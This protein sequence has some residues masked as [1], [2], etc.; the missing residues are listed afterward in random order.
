M[1]VLFLTNVGNRD[2]HVDGA[3]LAPDE[4]RARGELIQSEYK[5]RADK[6][7]RD[8]LSAPLIEP[9]LRM[10]L[11]A[12][13]PDDPAEVEVVL[14]VTDQPEAGTDP[15]HRARD[16]VHVGA[17]LERYLKAR[18]EGQQAG[19]RVAAVRSIK[20]T[21]NPSEHDAMFAFFRTE[22]SGRAFKAEA[23]CIYVAAVGGVPAANFALLLNAV[24]RFGDRCIPLY[25]PEGA[26][27]PIRLDVG[28][29]IR[30]DALRDVARHALE[31]FDFGRAARL[32][33]ELGAD[34]LLVAL[35][36]HAEHRL[37]F[38]FDRALAALD[39]CAV[40][41]GRDAERA[42]V[43]SLRDELVQLAERADAAA[44]IR[45]LFFNLRVTWRQGRYVDVLLRLFRLEEAILRHVVERDCRVP[46]DSVG[47][48]ADPRFVAFVEGDPGLKSHFEANKAGGRLLDYRREPNVPILS[49]LL[50][51]L[52][53]RAD[54][55]NGDDYRAVVEAVG[56]LEALTTLRNKSIGAH[57]FRGVSEAAIRE[58]YGRDCDLLADLEALLHT[59]GIDATDDPLVRV[60]D[61]VR[62]ALDRE[63]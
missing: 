9:C 13:A 24:H 41:A 59:V 2:L 46:T 7:Y 44:L 27:A 49:H 10:A 37:H 58:A 6:A 34:G 11:R 5:K 18:Y 30:R 56:R 32:L 38:D 1:R 21:R 55:A 12:G 39:A 23:D 40:P 4:M 33:E 31:G 17:V 29:R 3:P 16:S 25:L 14:F 26:R 57:G 54:A 62:A 63:R 35:A 22:L 50:A 60:R 47:G 45:E 48:K 28:E 15:R 36:G 61:F 43:R 52:A 20:I 42:L 51:G 19:A 8:R 53:Q